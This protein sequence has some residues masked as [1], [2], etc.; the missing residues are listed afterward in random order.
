MG[1]QR[2]RNRMAAVMAAA[3]ERG[4][5]G[6]RGAGHCDWHRP[7]QLGYLAFGAMAEGRYA[8]GERQRHCTVCQRWL[9]V[10][11]WGTPPAGAPIWDEARIAEEGDDATPG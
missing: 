6:P 8:K 1:R 2:D 7:S 3:R 5:V 10:D 9:F 11:E 4:M